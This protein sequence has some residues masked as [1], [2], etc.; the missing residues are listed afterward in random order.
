MDYIDNQNLLK[1]IFHLGEESIAI[2]GSDTRIEKCRFTSTSGRNAGSDESPPDHL[3]VTYFEGN[4]EFTYPVFI[5]KGLERSDGAVIMLHGLNERSWNKYL[6]WA[7]YLAEQ[8]GKAVILFPIAFHINRSPGFW[9]DPRTMQHVAATRSEVEERIACATPFNAALSS[10]LDVHPEWFCTS[11]LQTCNDLIIL[12]DS[13]RKGEHRL[14]SAGSKVDFFAYSVGAF[15]LE[16]L[17]IADPEAVFSESKSFLFLGGS[18]FEQ[19]KGISK[20]IMD[21]K[22]FDRLEE[23]FIRQDPQEVKQKIHSPHHANFNALWT[24]FMSMLRMDRLQ[25]FRERSFARLGQRISAIGL[26]RD[27]VIPGKSI[28]R[29]LWGATNRN[30][31]P[32]AIMDFPYPYLHEN[33]FPIQNTEMRSSIDGCFKNVFDQASRFLST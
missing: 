27:Q 21:S 14:F 19:M 5:P 22:A 9:S 4:E 15:L 28:L 32:V 30:H 1:N 11:G 23:V 33:P 24:S 25:A 6:Y 26:A 7:Q 13:I 17:L 8:T 10:R 16:V 3:L 12:T 29:T 18:S 2:P 20:Y 31:I